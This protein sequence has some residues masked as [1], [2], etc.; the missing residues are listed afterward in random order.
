MKRRYLFIVLIFILGSCGTS[1]PASVQPSPSP[2]STPTA[3]PTATPVPTTVTIWHNW[4]SS[5]EAIYETI[6]ADFNASSGDVRIESLKVENLTEA[7]RVAIPSGEGPDVVHGH[8]EQIGPWA[9]LGA[10]TPLGGYVAPSLLE[11]R[12]EPAAVDAVEWG[13]VQW[14]FPESQEGVAL[15]YNRD[16]LSPSDLPDPDDFDH[17]L[18]KA[19][20]YRQE[21]PDKYYLCNPGLGQIDAYSVAPI[22]LGH[23]LR[24]YGGFV[25]QDGNVYLSN[26]AAYDA[27]AWIAEF[28]KVAPAEANAGICQAMFIE[29]QVPIWWMGERA[30]LTLEETRVDY[31]IAPMGSPFVDVTAFMLSS[32]TQARGHMGAALTVI[33]YLTGLE[34]QRRL[35]LA[36]RLVPANSAALA[37]ASLQ[38]DPIIAGFGEAL[39]RGTPLPNHAFGDCAWGPV[40]DATLAIW[41]GRLAPTEAMNEAQ[42]I[43][44]A[45][46]AE[47]E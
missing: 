38:A 30:L 25:D 32:N 9:Q 40:G 6:I 36:V 23:G 29:G 4:P 11:N 43:V 15:I 28:S 18:Q 24:E 22:Y 39:R 13:D 16:M 21:N 37:D 10:I 14:G 3:T 42:A 46:V 2:T 44:E 5:W 47:N 12:F 31:G 17:L 8:A 26:G 27:A 33:Q 41:R 20:V 19:Q 7:L 34:A 35:A 45:C 1:T